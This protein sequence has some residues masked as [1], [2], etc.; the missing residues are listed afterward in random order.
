MNSRQLSR[1]V[2]RLGRRAAPPPRFATGRA[3][4]PTFRASEGL[5]KD[6]PPQFIRPQAGF[7]RA[8]ES[9]VRARRLRAQPPVP[10]PVRPL[11]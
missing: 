11:G 6:P 10:K 2:R 5:G 8:A 3:T 9:A 1:A 4:P 7:P